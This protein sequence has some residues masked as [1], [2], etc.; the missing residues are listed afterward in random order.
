ALQSQPPAAEELVGFRVPLDVVQEA[1]RPVPG[2]PA[3][4][5]AR[6]E[7]RREAS[8]PEAPDDRLSRLEGGIRAVVERLESGLACR[9]VENGRAA[10]DVPPVPGPEIPG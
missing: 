1:L 6:S 4:R 5:V 9:R 8:R 2:P 10:V 7:G 3:V